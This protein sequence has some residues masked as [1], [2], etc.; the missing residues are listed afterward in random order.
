MPS[1][2][3]HTLDFLEYI[4]KNNDR[5]HFMQAKSLYTEIRDQLVAFTQAVLDEV[6]TFDDNI[7]KDMTAKS[8][9]FRI[10]RD[11]R[12]PRNREHP[13]KWNFGFVIS[14]WG[15]NSS[16]AGYYV[17]IEPGGSFF[18][19][20]VYRPERT[21]LLNLRHFLAAHGDLYKKITKNPSFVK[22]FGI[23]HGES[24][25]RLPKVFTGYTPYL[26]IIARKQHLVYHKYTS[27]DILQEDWF[28]KLITDCKTAYD[29][30]ALLNQWLSYEKWI[31]SS[32]S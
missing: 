12:Y 3:P 15:K 14:A 26:D 5:E 8:C 6:R 23:I 29:F 31:T 13:Y 21:Q 2:H 30:F 1:L 7:E 25:S 19:W 28:D 10:Y 22:R 17:H 9:M 16:N 24:T 32:E 27:S 4:S 20:G 18:G 11:A